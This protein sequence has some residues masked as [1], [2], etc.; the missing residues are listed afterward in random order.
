MWAHHCTVSTSP[1]LS[2]CYSSWPPIAQLSLSPSLPYR[3]SSPTP[4]LHV[5]SL[6]GNTLV[7]EVDEPTLPHL[8]WAL[9]RVPAHNHMLAPV[10]TW[11]GQHIMRITCTCTPLY[12]VPQILLRAD[13]S[14]CCWLLKQACTGRTPTAALTNSCCYT[15]VHLSA[16]HGCL[17]LVQAGIHGTHTHTR[18]HA[19]T[20]A[21]THTHIAYAMS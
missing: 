13:L 6:T 3:I 12:V 1:G 19:R 11:P 20:R 14:R 2:N 7:F 5:L 4:Q 10:S 9:P 17:L 8:L 21:C 15:A 16:H 18:M